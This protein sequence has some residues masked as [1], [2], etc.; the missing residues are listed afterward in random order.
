MAELSPELS[1]WA[2]VVPHRFESPPK[3]FRAYFVA[4]DTVFSAYDCTHI[5][6]RFLIL[7]L[8]ADLSLKI[9]RNT[10]ASPANVTSWIFPVFP[11]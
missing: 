6:H 5:K 3:C 4:S 11:L 7:I 2:V 9:F 8:C 10:D 1:S